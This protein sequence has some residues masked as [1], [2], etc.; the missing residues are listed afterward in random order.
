M[1]KETTN[2]VTTSLG[3]APRGRIEQ[4][5]YSTGVISF[6]VSARGGGSTWKQIAKEVQ[7]KFDVKPTERQMRTWW[8]RYGI[9]IE[10][11]VKALTERYLTEMAQAMIA[12]AI[13]VGLRVFFPLQKQCQQ[14]GVSA[15]KAYW[16]TTLLVLEQIVGHENFGPLIQDYQNMSD[17][18]REGI[19]PE[20]IASVF[21]P[22]AD[23]KSKERRR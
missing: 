5:R 10:T 14:L 15:D 9:D 4:H 8:K 6:V 18:L 22:I 2:T 13:E 19:D 17:K 21:F 16:F 7:K 1:K 20:S 3:I 23:E 12:R 11:G